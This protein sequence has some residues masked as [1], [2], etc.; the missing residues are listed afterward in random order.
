MTDIGRVM[1]Y[2]HC[3]V[4]DMWQSRVYDE[5]NRLYYIHSG[6][7]GFIYNG[8]FIELKAGHLYFFPYLADVEPISDSSDKIVH[9]Y[10]NFELIPPIIS[11]EVMCFNPEGDT[12]AQSALATFIAGGKM[13]ILPAKGTGNIKGTYSEDFF[14]LCK[15]AISYLTSRTASASGA[16][17]IKDEIIIS[18]LKKMHSSL[19]E[20]ITVEGL[21]KS[22]YITPD[23]FIRR[24][25]GEIGITP[26]SYLKRLRIRTAYFL[27]DG[28]MSLEK[29]AKETGYSDSSSLLHAMKDFK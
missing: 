7:G 8:K 17:P 12:E 14:R 29:I 18:A 5:T 25:K 23:G 13:Q 4:P 21:A 22:Y 20:D 19:S 6:K 15:V 9:T 1:C 26:Y 16:K 24:F 2:G 11:K 3:A 28:G 10:A 27:K